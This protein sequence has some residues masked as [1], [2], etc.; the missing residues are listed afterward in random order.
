MIKLDVVV[1]EQM[2]QVVEEQEMTNESNQKRS[3]VVHLCSNANCTHVLKSGAVATSFIG[4][5][6]LCESGD[7]NFTNVQGTAVRRVS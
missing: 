7:V 4:I 1:E 3:K 6:P 5:C 2:A